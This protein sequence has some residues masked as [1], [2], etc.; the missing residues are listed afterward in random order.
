MSVVWVDKILTGPTK[1][2]TG[3]P[4]VRVGSCFLFLFDLLLLLY[5]VIIWFCCTKHVFLLWLIR[6]L[7]G[8]QR[9]KSSTVA[10]VA[11]FWPRNPVH[12]KGG[13]WKM[14][15]PPGARTAE[16]P[17][18]ASP[19]DT[20]SKET[21]S[22]AGHHCSILTAPAPLLEVAGSHPSWGG[23]KYEGSEGCCLTK[24]HAVRPPQRSPLRLICK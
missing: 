20:G 19:G 7:M 13:F 10:A 15:R 2:L 12:S 1:P 9:S 18:G 23:T 16:K 5:C 17:R 24:L 21:S 6:F 11:T 8:R 4:G 14:Q 3:Y 22:Y